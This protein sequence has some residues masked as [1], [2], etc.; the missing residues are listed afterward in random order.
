MRSLFPHPALS[1]FLALVWLVIAGSWSMASLVMAVL[2]G[3]I[4]PLAIVPLWPDRPRLRHPLG[5]IGYILIVLYDVVRSSFAVARIILF[6]PSAEIRSA[7]I[8]IPLDLTAPEAIALLAGTITM[9]PGTLTADYSADGRTLL[10]HAL[11]APDPDAVRDE[12][13][14]RYEARLKRIFG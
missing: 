8:A 3:V 7:W 2:A 6:M 4:V 5:L 13:K 11:H 1:V 10:V 9:T 14:S 12:I